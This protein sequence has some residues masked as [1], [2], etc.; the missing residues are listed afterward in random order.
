EVGHRGGEDGAEPE[1]VDPQLRKVIQ[2]LL[3]AGKVA[4]AV[5]GR[6]WEGAWID[7]V[8]GALVP[9]R[10]TAGLGHEAASRAGGIASLC[11]SG[12]GWPD[13]PQRARCL[14]FC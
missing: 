8:D 13:S 12:K 1:G 4:R 2:T 11:G 3:D 6:G 14:R 7:L 10:S 9:P 5:A